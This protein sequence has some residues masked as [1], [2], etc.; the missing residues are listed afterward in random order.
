MKELAGRS[1]LQ[2]SDGELTVLRTDARQDAYPDDDRK[3]IGFHTEHT[4]DQIGAA[5][6]RW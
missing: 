3:F 5:S 1:S 4:D 6:L 2:V